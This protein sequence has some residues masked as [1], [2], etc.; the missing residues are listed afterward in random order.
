MR[1]LFGEST[2]DAVADDILGLLK[3][4]PKGVTRTD[5]S[6]YFGRNLPA[7]RL[8]GALNE[9]LKA[10]SVRV[11]HNADTGGR[12]AEVWFATAAAA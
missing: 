7:A 3:S 10:G 5:I 6:N 2:G 8:K 9:L 12:P 11:E 1:Y 4:C